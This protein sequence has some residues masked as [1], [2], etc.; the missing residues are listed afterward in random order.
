VTAKEPFFLYLPL[1]SPHTPLVPTEEWQGKSG[2]G[3]YGDFV[4]ETDWAIGEMLKTLDRSGAASNTLVM[5]ASDNGCAPYIGVHQ[6]E[7]QGHFPSA[8][9]RGYKA[10]IWDGGHRIPFVVRWPG[11]VKAGSECDQLICLM[12]LMAT[13]ADILDVKIPENA[14]ED[15][16]SLLPALLGKAKT[17]LREALVSHSGNG[18]FAIRQGRWKLELCPGSGGWSEPR[19]GSKAA[20]ALP[21]LQ[22]YDMEKD[23]GERTNEYAT[24]PEIVARLMTLLEKDVADGRSTSGRPQTN[25]VMIQTRKAET[26]SND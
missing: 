10:D 21:P 2:L 24:H 13:C 6:L 15:S 12:D 9:R 20:H 1:T 22:L 17:P 26:V 4:M 25:D 8:E 14:G 3:D 7:E 18:S 5:L 11:K 23:V 16:V 19:P